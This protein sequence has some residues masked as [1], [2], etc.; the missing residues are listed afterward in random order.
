[1]VPQTFVAVTGE[2]VKLPDDDEVKQLALAVCNHL[3]ELGSVVC[4]AR[5]GPVGIGANDGVAVALCVGCTLFDLALNGFLSLAA[6]RITG[7]D[8]CSHRKSPC[9]MFG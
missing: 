5:N 3:L 8:N 2:A 4:G 9:D 6:G 7:I 1:M